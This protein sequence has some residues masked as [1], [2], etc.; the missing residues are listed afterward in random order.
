MEYIKTKSAQKA[1]E[2][3]LK[4]FESKDDRL[5]V[6]NQEI[7]G[8]GGMC[9]CVTHQS[10]HWALALYGEG[11]THVEI[12]TGPPC[13]F[14]KFFPAN[15]STDLLA[16][17][18]VFSRKEFEKY[19]KAAPKDKHGQ[20]TIL[21][22]ET[23]I[24]M[25]FIYNISKVLGDFTLITGRMTQPTFMLSEYGA[26]IVLSMLYDSYQKQITIEEIVEGCNED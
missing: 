22:G 19:Y 21:F 7:V 3:L 1:W 11:M 14:N 6:W 5:Y 18:F 15:L 10:G 13:D 20:K 8:L 4:G 2:T 12:V 16:N 24:N 23:K 17:K 25:K 9:Q 26:A